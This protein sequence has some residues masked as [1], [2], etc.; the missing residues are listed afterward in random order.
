MIRKSILIKMHLIIV[1]QH[2]K[3][4]VH[5]FIKAPKLVHMLTNV[6]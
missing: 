3:P 6:F 1:Q 4:I 5:F 2:S